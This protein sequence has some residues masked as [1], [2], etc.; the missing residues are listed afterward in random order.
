MAAEFNF[1]TVGLFTT[2]NARM[3]AFYRD[4]MGLEADWNGVEPDVRLSDPEG[5]MIEIHSFTKD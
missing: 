2:D 5:N 3:V 1:N 4:I